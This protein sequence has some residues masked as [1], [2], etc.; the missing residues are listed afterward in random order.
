MHSALGISTHMGW[1]AV[2]A[3]LLDAG[4][5]RQVRTFRLATAAPADTE[6][7][8]PYHAAAGYRGA[9]RVRPPPDPERVVRDALRRQRR[10]TEIQLGR[11][12][13]ELRDW[14]APVQAALF[15]GRGRPAASLERILASHAQI[16]VAE[17]NAVRG[18]VRRALEGRTIG[19]LPLDRRELPDRVRALL[20]I[21]APAAEQ[22]L[23]GLRPDNGGVWRREE[24]DCALAAWLA[25]AGRPAGEPEPAAQDGSG[26][27]P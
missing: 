23:R 5:P 27:S 22:V 3:L 21:D 11:L 9:T 16:H 1:A 18:A 8:E 26:F 19:T 14:P 24:R 25:G 2:A 20:G 4:T 10:Y 15:V 17:G 7:A 6:A 12:L 13:R